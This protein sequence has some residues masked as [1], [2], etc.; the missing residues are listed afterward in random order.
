M[1]DNCFL[2]FIS[3]AQNTCFKINHRNVGLR[4][5]GVSGLSTL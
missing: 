4:L 3:N 2:I 5:K 1:V